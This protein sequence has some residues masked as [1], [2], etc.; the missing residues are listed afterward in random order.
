MLKNAGIVEQ[1]AEREY[2]G[3][4]EPVSYSSPEDNVDVI[5]TPS[6]KLKITFMVDYNHACVPTQY[7]WLPSMDLFEKQFAPARTF[8]FCE[9]DN[10]SQR[11]RAD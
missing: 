3:L 7:T 4:T 1:E 5:I 10:L 2:F 8:C 9:R 6:D 11:K